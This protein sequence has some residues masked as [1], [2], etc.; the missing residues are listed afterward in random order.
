MNCFLPSINAACE[1]GMACLDQ[2][3]RRKARNVFLWKQDGMAM[4]SNKERKSRK[5]DVT[6]YSRNEDYSM[7][8]ETRDDE[9]ITSYFDPKFVQKDTRDEDT[10]TDASY[11][12]PKIA[13]T[14]TTDENTDTDTDSVTS[15][16][17]QKY[18]T[19]NAEAT[20]P[21]TALGSNDPITTLGSTSNDSIGSK[22]TEITGGTLNTKIST[23]SWF[24]ALTQQNQQHPEIT[25]VWSSADSVAAVKASKKVN[26]SVVQETSIYD[27]AFDYIRKASQQLSKKTIDPPSD[28]S[29]AT[30]NSITASEAGSLLRR[31]IIKQKNSDLT[32]A[33]IK[34]RQMDLKQTGTEP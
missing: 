28:K 2:E 32:H 13:E 7:T 30:S 16:F 8:K 21:S 5:K 4:S 24:Q 10:D 17:N 27:S 9:S 14:D 26:N 29:V 19:G 22:W 25:N 6:D 3:S 34:R 33:I 1:P 20:Y 12:N 15:Y 31:R 18:A 11:F 23:A